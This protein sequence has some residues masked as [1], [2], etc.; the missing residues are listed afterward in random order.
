MP[1]RILDCQYGHCYKSLDDGTITGTLATVTGTTQC[2][3]KDDGTITDT[4]ATG[5]TQCAG[6]NSRLIQYWYNLVLG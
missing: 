3:S 4:V 6:K 1:V 2:A 5:T